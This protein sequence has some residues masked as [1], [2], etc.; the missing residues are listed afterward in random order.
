MLAGISLKGARWDSGRICAYSN[1]V[2]LYY[3]VMLGSLS[4]PMAN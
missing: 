3:L 2:N 4:V 1:I